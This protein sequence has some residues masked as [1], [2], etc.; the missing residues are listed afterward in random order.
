MQ[1]SNSDIS[2]RAFFRRQDKKGGSPSQ[3]RTMSNLSPPQKPI[4]PHLSPV[5]PTTPLHP[6]TTSEHHKNNND[7]LSKFDKAFR[8]LIDNSPVISRCAIHHNRNTCLCDY[9]ANSTITH[10][11]ENHGQN[12]QC[13]HHHQRGQVSPRLS[14][15]MPGS[16]AGA[17]GSG[18]GGGSTP[19]GGVG[20]VG[21]LVPPLNLS[22]GEN[23]DKE[24][25]LFVGGVG[26]V[27]GERVEHFLG[28]DVHSKQETMLEDAFN[29]DGVSGDLVVPLV[30][31]DNKK[32]WDEN[33]K[34]GQDQ[35]KV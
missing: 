23:K 11:D 22:G 34:L 31:T 29:G 8:P 16:G 20:G 26:G 4:S 24:K 10:H 19:P 30:D 15:E 32:T 12:C 6:T 18:E 28:E 5:S 21:V 13:P 2:S 17:G 9:D 27:Q 33:S 3:T 25:E 1:N 35:Q 14:F 7:G